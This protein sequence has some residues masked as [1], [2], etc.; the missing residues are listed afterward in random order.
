MPD[1]LSPFTETCERL[2]QH[3]L[4]ELS[5]F[6]SRDFESEKMLHLLNCYEKKLKLLELLNEVPDAPHNSVLFKE[7]GWASDHNSAQVRSKNYEQTTATYL[8]LSALCLVSSHN[9]SNEVYL[10]DE[11]EVNRVAG[12]FR[13]NANMTISP[14]TPLRR[15]L[16][17]RI[18]VM[19]RNSLYLES[20]PRENI[21]KDLDVSPFI[22]HSCS[23]NSKNYLVSSRVGYICGVCSKQSRVVQSWESEYQRV[24]KQ[25]GCTDLYRFLKVSPELTDLQKLLYWTRS[26]LPEAEATHYL[27]NE[28]RNYEEE[29]VWENILKF[30][31]VDNQE[32]DN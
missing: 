28:L 21:L 32:N 22:V 16:S 20:N 30:H 2:V 5:G 26:I 14:K 6:I 18:F 3:A 23:Q 10:T 7:F 25:K 1:Q 4:S 13:Y 27:I 19:E 9:L 11:A 29:K 17:F 8:V 12:R 15:T 24:F 31:T